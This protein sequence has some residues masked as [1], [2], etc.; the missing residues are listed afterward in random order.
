MAQED[1][2]PS[3]LEDIIVSVV[4]EI[5]PQS[6]PTGVQPAH[7]LMRDLGFTSIETFEI[8]ALIDARLRRRFPYES[9]I[10]KDGM[11]A[12]DLTVEEIV[13]FLRENWNG[14][15]VVPMAR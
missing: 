7:Y 5:G 4:K 8:F 1:S 3:N 6:S 14:D 9:L 12:E 13:S 15:D 10:I 2:C 11:I